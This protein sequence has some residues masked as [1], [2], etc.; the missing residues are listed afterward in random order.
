[1][2]KIRWGRAELNGTRPVAPKI[3]WGRA[4][5][6]GSA[7]VTLRPFAPQVDVEPQTVITLTAVTF[8]GSA[9]PTSY[10]WRQVSGPAVTF[11]GSGD[12]RTFEA[13]S[14]MTG[15]VVVIGVAGV[16]A[17]VTGPEQV[18]SITVLPQLSWIRHPDVASGAWVGSKVIVTGI[19]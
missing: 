18:A 17:G 13:P 1:M 2:A 15:G 4:A 7:S 8:P 11:S 3:R 10:V 9:D 6:T 19:G 16:L 14:S 5:V 12:T